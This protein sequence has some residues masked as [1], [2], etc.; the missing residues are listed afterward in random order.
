MMKFLSIRNYEQNWD[1]RSQRV[2]SILNIARITILFS[3]LIFLAVIHNLKDSTFT[4]T[5][6]LPMVRNELWIQ[7]WC[8]IYGFIIMVSLAHPSWQVQKHHVMPNA[9]AVID[10]T[11]IAILT[12]LAGG[13]GSGFGILLLP[14]LATSCLLSHGNYPLLYGS[15]ASS[16]VLSEII[17]R[18]S[19][20]D[21]SNSLALFTGQI[22]LIG[23]CYTVPLLTSLSARHLAQTDDS[24]REHQNA[25]EQLSALNKIVVNRM[26]EAVLVVD[27]TQRLWLYNRQAKEYFPDIDQ[28][29]LATF[30]QELIVRSRIEPNYEFESTIELEHQLMHIR[31][32]PLVNNNTRLLMLF[33]RSDKERQIEAQTV[34]LAS[35]GLLTA[36][37]AHEIRNPLSAMRQASGLL[38]E[39]AE[40]SNLPNIERL[41]NIIEKNIG[42]IDKMIEEVSA[43]NKRDKINTEIINLVK[44][45]QNFAQEFQLTRPESQ[46]CLTLDIPRERF[47]VLFDAMHLQQILWNLCNNA[48]R[49]CKKQKNSIIVSIRHYG[50]RYVALRV[51]DDGTGVPE[52][53]QVHLFEPFQ[54]TEAEGTGLGLY[55]GREL[56]H[57]NRGDLQYLAH[58]KSFELTLPRYQHDKK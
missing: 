7:I 31:A 21:H 8:G 20:N 49:H 54:T 27:D 50:N 23:A 53:V 41:S 39:S 34:K 16:L 43:L 24:L 37:L 35:L 10:I 42:R 47:D 5:T 13:T 46:G 44:F 38:A 26:Q 18:Y 12:A 48:W 28:S 3:L 2:L 52:S 9:S 1:E 15:Y 25:Y 45:W 33:I 36:N 6:Y 56:A 32:I 4:T 19:Q 51:W 17:W 14:F 58:A 30:T 40:E 22:L 55:V 57:A 29:E 11:M